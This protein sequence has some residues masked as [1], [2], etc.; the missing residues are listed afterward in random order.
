MHRIGVIGPE[1]SVERILKVA[2]EFTHEFRFIPFVYE[3]EKEIQEILQ[4][5][6]GKVSGWLFSG[7][8]PYIL[9]GEYLEAGDTAAYCQ[10]MGGGLYQCCLQMAFAQNVILPRISVDIVEHEVNVEELLHA[11]GLP[12]H[13][14]HV[15]YYNRQYEAEEIIQFHLQLWRDGKIDGVITALRCVMTALE[16]EGVPVYHFTLTE[17]EIYHSIKIIIEKVKSSYFKNTQ[18]GL[19]LIEVGSYGEIIEKAKTSYDLQLLEL[20][21]KEILL[22]LCKRLDGYLLDKGTGIYEIFSSRGAVERELAM[23]QDTMERL[24]LAVNVDVLIAAGIGFGETVFAT[25]INAHRALRN[26]RGQKDGRIVIVQDDGKMIEIGK[27][28]Q[29]LSYDFYSHDAD[30]LNQLNQAGVGIRTYRK[31][32]KI[33]QHIG[34]G[35]FSIAQLA[36]QMSVTERNVR[37]I[38]TNLCNAGLV[39]I[40]GEEYAAVRGRPSKLYQLASPKQ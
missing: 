15:K 7:P 16:K 30:L 10:T 40:A 38:I 25:E 1:P 2:G 14:F 35:I 8:V 12:W 17:R 39:D 23:L 9:A 37:R 36:V 27:R 28:D 22:P 6:R 33:V 34:G 20:K 19:V 24:V 3:D 29:V 5:N 32:E 26:T 18:V 13:D 31:I 11:T 4:Q 21:L